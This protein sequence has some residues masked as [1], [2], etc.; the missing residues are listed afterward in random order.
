MKK[1]SKKE[2]VKKELF[3]TKV[4][5]EIKQV[6]WPNRKEMIKYSVATLICI[7]VLSLFFVASDLIIAA[8]KSFVEGL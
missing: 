8:A 6:R 7:I 4:R 3:I 1:V 5:K 2:K